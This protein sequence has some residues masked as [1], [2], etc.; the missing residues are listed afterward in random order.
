MAALPRSESKS[1]LDW[2]ITSRDGPTSDSIAVADDAREVESP[3]RGKNAGVCVS[4]NA[5]E[6]ED[7][8][9]VRDC[10][11]MELEDEVKPFASTA[12]LL[13]WLAAGDSKRIGR[14]GM[15]LDS[16]VILNDSDF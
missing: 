14:N 8:W 5:S 4:W 13:P 9:C 16:F 2:E 6:E 1:Q 15:A 7:A 11:C 3:P 10:N 12:L